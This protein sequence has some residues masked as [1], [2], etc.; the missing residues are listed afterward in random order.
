MMKLFRLVL[1]LCF[2]LTVG[3]I[4]QESSAPIL[5]DQ[6][7]KDLLTLVSEKTPQSSVEQRKTFAEAAFAEVNREFPATTSA[8]SSQLETLQAGRCP[9]TDDQVRQ[10]YADLKSLANGKPMPDIVEFYKQK[11]DASQS[12]AMQKTLYCNLSSAISNRI[13]ANH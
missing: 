9:F 1:F 11:F 13:R 2:F 12:N 3:A 8:T 4:A 7:K 6:F 5:V 10:A